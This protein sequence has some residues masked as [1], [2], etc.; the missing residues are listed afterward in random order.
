MMMK[1]VL[2]A[3]VLI[4]LVLV[5]VIE[6]PYWLVDLVVALV[7]EIALWEYCNLAN[8][9]GVKTARISSFIAVAF[10][11]FAT[12]WRPELLVTLTGAIPLAILIVCV[13]HSP[14]DRAL[15]DTA[16]SVFGVLY[17]GLSLTTLPL[18]SQQDNGPAL[19]IFLLFVV[20]AGDS[21]ALYVGRAWGRRK[22]APSISPG[23]TWEG[24]I[25]SVSG[26]LII[27]GLLLWFAVFLQA[28]GV[29][30]LSYP[31]SVIRWLVLAVIVNVAAQVGDLIESAIKRGAGVKDS[32]TLLPGHGGM[33]DRIDALLLAAPIL[34]YALIIQQ[35]F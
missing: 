15:A 2:T 22:L 32:G 34:W 20:W 23:K 35:S 25:A 29:T 11:Y 26:S 24:S 16:F 10:L 13:F 21:T 8:V 9:S 4:P 12:Y 14:L 17:I 27:T 31:G 19:L 18:L 3:L 30:T 33:L 28:H 5:L 7:A 1:R 6:R